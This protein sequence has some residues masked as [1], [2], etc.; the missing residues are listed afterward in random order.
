VDTLLQIIQKYDK[1][2]FEGAAAGMEYIR[3]SLK[4]DEKP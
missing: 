3:E 2:M 1:K 4:Y